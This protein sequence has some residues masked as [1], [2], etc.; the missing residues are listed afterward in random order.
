MP[1]MTYHPAMLDAERERSGLEDGLHKTSLLLAAA[2]LLLGLAVLFGWHTGNRTLVQLLPQF[3]PMQYNTAL[4]FVACGAALLGLALGRDR[5]ALVAGGLAV[6]VGS[7]TLFEYLGGVDLGIDELFMTHDVTTETSHPGRMAPNTAIC[8]S[9]VGLAAAFS[10]AGWSA[11]A[12]SVLRVVLTSLAMGL[13]TVALS[14]YLAE[15]ETA[16]GWGNLT[17]MALHTSVGF[18][19]VSSG[20]VCLVWSRDLES[21]SG[22]PRWLP[23]PIAIGILTATLCFWQALSAESVR[24]ASVQHELS[25]LANVM[26]VVGTLL[27]GA[28]ALSAYLAQKSNQR[29]KQLAHANQLLEAHG[30][31]LESLVAERTKEL[32]QSRTEAESADRAKSTFLANMSHELRT[33]MNAIIGYSEMLMEEAE[34]IEGDCFTPDLERINGAGRHLLALIND[35]LDLSKIEAGKMALHLESFDLDGLIDDVASTVESLVKTKGNELV[36]ERRG[37]LGAVKADLTK[38]RQ[39]LFNLLSNAAKFTEEGRITLCVSRSAR[40]DG[41][42]I[43]YSVSDSG[44][45]IPADKLGHLFEEFS[46]VD[47]STTRD[48][49]GTGLGLAITKRFS[50]MMGG[51]VAVESQPGQGSTFTIRLPAEVLEIAAPGA[52][53]S[54]SAES[55][56]P[57]VGSCIL[58]IDD[59]AASLDLIQRSLE[60]DGHRVAVASSGDEGLRLARELKPVLITLDVLMPG[61]DGWAVLL[62]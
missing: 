37:E 45:G 17:R 6:L 8:F 30:E 26:L 35:I 21:D 54:G 13:S 61:K 24:I 39:V 3:V 58:V 29:A 9:L 15:L 59:D 2:T 52:A 10:P 31:N 12:R 46:Q 5:L 51:T 4:G 62:S 38:L 43:V 20:M 7:L 42:W 47:T 23:A 33:P 48:Y 16:Y 49:G 22:L 57:P 28:M 27:S 1:G 40:A 11:G 19:L 41:D 56:V 50:E 44:I 55:D 34:D 18:I 32:V 36:I 14:G 53:A 60:R 25:L